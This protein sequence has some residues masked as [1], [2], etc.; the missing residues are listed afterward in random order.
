MG[1]TLKSEYALRMLI[2]LSKS[3]DEGKIL[4]VNK[5][6][7][8]TGNSVPGE[9]AEKILAILRRRGII[10]TVRGRKGG[11]RLARPPEQITLADVIYSL[12]KPFIIFK[13]KNMCPENIKC[14]V[15]K[16]WNRVKEEVDRTLRS[17]T[18]RDLLEMLD[19]ESIQ[20]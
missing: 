16:V 7:E 17:M 4:S 20:S 3:Y 9:F 5:I 14:V 2:V 1:F 10:S 11:Y 13:D 18:L 6:L 19:E 15:E 12:E 8:K